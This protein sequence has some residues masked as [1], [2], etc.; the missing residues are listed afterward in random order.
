MSRNFRRRLERL[1]GYGRSNL[2]LLFWDLISGA[3]KFADLPP[4]TRDSIQL[5]LAS[6]PDGFWARVAAGPRDRITDENDPIEI[7]LSLEAEKP[8]E[9]DGGGDRPSLGPGR[10]ASGP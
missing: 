5:Y 9:V 3:V 10:A 2:N 7:R 8:D 6:D 1:E 4:E